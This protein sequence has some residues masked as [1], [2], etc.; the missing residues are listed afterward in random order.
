MAG[1][2]DDARSGNHDRLREQAQCGDFERDGEDDA[3]GAGFH[4]EAPVERVFVGTERSM[5][6]GQLF[7]NNNKEKLLFYN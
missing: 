3:L 2:S 7:L 5:V 6:V 1:A 4:A